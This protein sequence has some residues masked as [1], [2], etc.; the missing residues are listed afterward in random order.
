M[1]V[2]ILIYH[3]Q[4]EGLNIEKVFNSRQS[5]EKFIQENYSIRDIKDDIYN[6][7]STDWLTIDEY[8]VY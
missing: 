5:A 1:I 8:L 7:D 2:Y 3:I 4:H 6:I